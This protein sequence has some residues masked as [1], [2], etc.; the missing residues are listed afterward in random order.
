MSEESKEAFQP[1]ETSQGLPVVSETTLKAVM[2]QFASGGKGRRW[3]EHLET[4]KEG[5]IK[6]NPNLVEFIEKQVGR[7]PAE[8]HTPMFEVIVG[9]VA[10]LE[11]QANANKTMRLFRKDE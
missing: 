10:L 5:L 6:E 1:K 3:G 4:V 9:T 11:H 2:S 8:L 7:Y